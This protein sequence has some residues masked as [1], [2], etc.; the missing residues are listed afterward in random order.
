[1]SG[2]LFLDFDGVLHPESGAEPL[3][4]RLPL[5]EQ[6]L[7][8]RPNIHVVISSSWRFSHRQDALAMHFSKDI[9]PRILGLTP[10]RPAEL[11]GEAYLQASAAGRIARSLECCVWMAGSPEPRR[12]WAALDDVPELFEPECPELVLCN[13]DTGLTQGELDELDQRLGK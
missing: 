5:L 10:I 9:R 3:F 12:R 8:A 2:V 4:C 11:A 6:W 1:M 13:A 7:R